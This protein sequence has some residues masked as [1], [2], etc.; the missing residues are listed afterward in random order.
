MG[1]A[2]VQDSSMQVPNIDWR[3]P[4]PLGPVVRYF[5]SSVNDPP[6]YGF[7]VALGE[8]SVDLMVVTANY[9]GF[10]PKN[11]VRHA[12]D[13]NNWKHRE[14]IGGLWLDLAFNIDVVNRLKDLEDAVSG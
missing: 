6:S 3:M 11:G 9:R 1:A 7:V 10:L 5:P 12:N 13:P 4:N 2:M 8:S 14:Y